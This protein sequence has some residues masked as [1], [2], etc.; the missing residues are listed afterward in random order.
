MIEHKIISVANWK[1]LSFY[2]IKAPFL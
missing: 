1:S 2:T